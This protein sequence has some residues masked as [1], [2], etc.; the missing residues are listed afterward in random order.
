MSLRTSPVFGSIAYTRTV[1]GVELRLFFVN[2]IFLGFCFIVLKNLWLM[3]GSLPL[4]WIFL[5]L[6]KSDPDILPIYSIYRF[7]GKQFSPQLPAC[8]AKTN[9]RPEGFGQRMPF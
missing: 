4:H 2:M 7:Q 6:T 3:L 5:N 9:L 1:M 8:H